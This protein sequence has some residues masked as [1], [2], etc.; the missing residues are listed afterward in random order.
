[1]PNKDRRAIQA[2]ISKILFILLLSILLEYQ[3]HKISL[4]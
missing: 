1:M 4:G 2:Q 3:V